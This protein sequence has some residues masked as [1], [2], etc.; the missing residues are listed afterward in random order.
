MK[1]H[2]RDY[3]IVLGVSV[4]ALGVIVSIIA[5]FILVC[6]CGASPWWFMLL[7]VSVLMFPIPLLYFQQ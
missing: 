3:F 2:I 7:L 6:I 1:N 5:P 4:A